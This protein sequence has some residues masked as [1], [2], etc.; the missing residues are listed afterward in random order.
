MKNISPQKSDKKD[1]VRTLI[2]FTVAFV[3]SEFLIVGPLRRRFDKNNKSESSIETKIIEKKET[4]EETNI[5]GK[6]IV[7]ENDYIRLNVNTKGMLIDDLILKKYKLEVNGDEK[8]KLLN[9]DDENNF[10]FI[11]INWISVGNDD[12]KLPN[13][14]SVWTSNKDSLDG[15]D[16]EIVFLYDN[17]EGVVFK[18]ILSLDEKY[19]INVEQIIENNTDG[20]IYVKPVWQIQQKQKIEKRNSLSD[21]SDAIGVFNGK[22]EEIKSRKLKNDSNREFKQFDWSGITSK[23]WLTAIINRDYS[24]GQINFLKTGD[25]LKMQYITKNNIIIQKKSSDGIKNSIFAGA[26]DINI[27][28]EY[29]DDRNIKLFSRSIDFGLFYFLSKPLYLILSFFNKITHNFGIAIVLLTVVIKLLLYPVVKKSFISMAKMKKVQP[30][31]KRIQ[32]IYK[33]DKIRLQQELVKIY[34]KNELNPLSGIVPLFIQIPVFFSLYKVISISID[35]RQAKFFGYIRDLSISDPTTIFNLF[36]LLP[37][38]PRFIVGLLPCLMSLTMYIQ[39]KINDN[40]QGTNDTGTS[41]EMKSAN[42]M[43]KYIPLV[44][45]FT[46]SG[47]PSGLLL[48]WI[49]NN[50]ITIIQQIYI[51]KKYIGAINDSNGG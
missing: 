24:N 7:L 5:E 37:Y 41:E 39:Q 44:F 27:L 34:K 1:A 9:H 26:K 48:Y 40:I 25:V 47:F 13:R 4:Y 30:E 17:R 11:D 33:S 35:M 28:K 32:E 43:M 3:I 10:Y 45:L 50:I 14:K 23:Y 46:F 38:N 51:N 20:K 15:T 6:N 49:F 18:I 42:K 29:Q 31:I 22:L 8:V 36:G 19:L 12:I 16:D 21:G 2:L